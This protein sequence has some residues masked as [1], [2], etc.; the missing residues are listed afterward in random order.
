MD[1]FSKMG[2]KL[3]L[4]YDCRVLEQIFPWQV[5]VAYINL[6]EGYRILPQQSQMQGL[7]Q[8]IINTTISIMYALVMVGLF[9][10]F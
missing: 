3:V 7:I 10:I 1:D 5:Y 8:F 6:A 4:I 9:S 2:R